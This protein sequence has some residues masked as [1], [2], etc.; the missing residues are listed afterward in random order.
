M[1]KTQSTFQVDQSICIRC[2]DVRAVLPCAWDG[3]LRAGLHQ[4]AFQ[5]RAA[6]L[7]LLTVVKAVNMCINQTTFFKAAGG[8]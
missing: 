2:L 5:A 6:G 3:A 1:E 4:W 8:F 7:L